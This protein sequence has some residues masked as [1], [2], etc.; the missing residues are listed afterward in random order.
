MLLKKETEMTY[1]ICDFQKEISIKTDENMK[2][3]EKIQNLK[4]KVK[5]A[6][7]EVLDIL[8]RPPSQ[9]EIIEK[10]KKEEEMNNIKEENNDLSQRNR[11]LE[12]SLQK[13]T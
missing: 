2:M 7:Q 9:Q 4:E 12:K 13:M 11:K 6:G 5:N 1:K 8:N 10:E 3:K